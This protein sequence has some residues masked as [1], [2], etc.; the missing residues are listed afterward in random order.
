MENEEKQI[1]KILA[2]GLAFGKQQ[3][4]DSIVGTTRDDELLLNPE[5]GE[6]L[7]KTYAPHAKYPDACN[8]AIEMTSN[9]TLLVIMNQNMFVL[10]VLE[11]PKDEVTA[12][13]MPCVKDTVARIQNSRSIMTQTNR[14]LN[15]ITGVMVVLCILVLLFLRRKMVM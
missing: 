2:D 14:K 9:I 6:R 8:Y 4:R 12:E 11:L 13:P 10:D 5:M 3:L 1:D 15:I 7:V